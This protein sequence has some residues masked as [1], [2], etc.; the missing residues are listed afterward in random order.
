[1]ATGGEAVWMRV[2]ISQAEQVAAMVEPL[3][4]H[5]GRSGAVEAVANSV[6]FHGSAQAP[7]ITGAALAVDGGYLA[8]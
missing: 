4:A 3:L 1:M 7:L 5:H 6:L 2:A 8:V